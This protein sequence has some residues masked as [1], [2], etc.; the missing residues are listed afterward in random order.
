MNIGFICCSL[1]LYFIFTFYVF[2]EK[3]FTVLVMQYQNI[4]G[5]NL[6]MS[7]VEE[8]LCALLRYTY[9]TFLILHC[10]GHNTTPS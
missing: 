7:V 6:C 4:S 10:K 9:K 5:Q 8:A 1:A 2:S 3:L